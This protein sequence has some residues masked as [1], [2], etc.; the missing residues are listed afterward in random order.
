MHAA[1]NPEQADLK[2]VANRLASSV[3]V[4]NPSDLDSHD[5]EKAWRL[6][7]DAGALSLRSREGGAPLASGTE[8]RLFVEAASAALLTAPLLGNSLAVDLLARTGASDDLVESIA[9]G[10]TRAGVLLSRDLTALT[11]KQDGAAVAWDVEGAATVIGIEPASGSGARVVRYTLDASSVTPTPTDATRAKGKILT[12]SGEPAGTVSGEDLKRWL[13]LALTLA[14][15]DA[16][17]AARQ[18]LENAIAYSRERH[19]YGRPIGSFQALQHLMV[20]AYVELQPAAALTHH[21]AWA[22]DV[23]DPAEALLAAR[24]AKATT[25]RVTLGVAETAMQVFGGIGVTKEHIAHLFSRRVIVDRSL[26]GDEDLHYSWIADARQ[27][28][29]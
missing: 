19:A 11:G 23:L 25:A 2:R 26:F 16:L 20:D 9:D 10:K 13:A 15:A 8:V 24:A 17:G 22:V 29:N 4:R 27:A 3:A 18:T 5:R 7:V 12:A 28:V 21:A 1:L 14:A 6:L